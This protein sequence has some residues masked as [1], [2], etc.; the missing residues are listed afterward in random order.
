M[1]Q[2]REKNISKDKI[3]KLTF[4]F[5]QGKLLELIK[6]AKQLILKYPDS[7]FL[8]NILGASNARLKKLNESEKCF[9]T[10]IK[11]NPNFIEGHYNLGK[12]QKELGKL[13]EAILSYK[14]AI[15]IKPD[16]AEAY[17][18]LGNTQK[19]LGKL[20]EAILSY[21][22]AIEIKPDYAEAYNNLG[23]TQKELGKLTEAILSYKKA[24][25]IKPD[26]AEFYNEIGGAQ[27][28]LG[29]ISE[30]VS[31][32]KKAIEIKPD[33]AEAY[34]NYTDSVKIQINDPILLKL[35]KLINKKNL[36][37]KDS[38]YLFFAM[39]KAQ[40]DIGN[41]EKALQLINTGNSLRKKELKYKIQKSKDIFNKIKNNFKE[42]NI[43]NEKT[44]P[45]SISQ[46][47]FIVGMPRSGTTL[48][49][50]ILSSHSSIYGAGELNF[51]DN[52]INLIDWQNNKIQKKDII[53]IR[54]NYINELKKI[55]KSTYTTDKM[56][57]NF[58]WIGFI[59]YAFPN[60]KI[61]HVK[62][63]AMATC[64]SNYKTNF[65]KSGLAF[66]F[67]QI[68]IVEYY[69]LYENLMDFWQKKF[70]GKIYE[71]NY[72]K[73]TEN[74]ELESRKIFNY[75]GLKWENSVLEF[76]N[77]SRIVQTA[78]NIQVRKKMYKGSSQ[79]WKKYKSWLQPMLNN[80][81]KN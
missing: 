69:K 57:L 2:N 61:I 39:G 55:S 25:E 22:K 65:S 34:N 66:A 1:K 32:Y 38:T 13:T 54:K 28:E 70:P 5:N 76:H 46:P 14:K 35:D 17:N 48:V 44:S 24:I 7:I 51:L 4:L 21:K 79:Q 16:Y 52:A 30:G 20:T 53:E 19:E 71:L 11:L 33:F 72:D 64:W 9:Y 47:I 78:S 8:W 3:E 31:S 6:E 73:L 45:D 41:S 50:Q 36:S 42:L 63:D 40:L 15:E 56:P 68:D 26:F 10:S 74:Q 75:L 29:K 27:I 59:A 43:K 60:A 49:E 80:L 77:N 58:R 12:T 37:E 18:N 81:K 62:R 67:D 23:N